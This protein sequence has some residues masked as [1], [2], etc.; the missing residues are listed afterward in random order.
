MNLLRLIAQGFTSRGSNYL[1]LPSDRTLRIMDLAATIVELLARRAPT[2]TLCPSEV[3]RALCTDEAAWR[4]LMPAVRDAAFVLA[5]RGA[6]DITQGGTTRDPDAP[7]V[8]PIRLRRGP[9]F[10]A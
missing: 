1:L 7:L 5:R 8:G 9:A 3:A 2:A 4:A 6:I 10:P